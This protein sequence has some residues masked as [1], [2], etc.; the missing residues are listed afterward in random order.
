MSTDAHPTISSYDDDFIHFSKVLLLFAWE[1]WSGPASG[2]YASLGV[3]CRKMAGI[4]GWAKKLKREGHFPIEEF[5]E[6][7]VE[8]FPFTLGSLQTGPCQGIEI[9]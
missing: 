3:D 2:F 8:E 9:T 7:K 5:K 6:I 4:M 1:Q